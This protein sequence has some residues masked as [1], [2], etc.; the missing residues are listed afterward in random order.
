MFIV[1]LAS[2]AGVLKLLCST[3]VTR[4]ERASDAA[5]I[6]TIIIHWSMPK[7]TGITTKCHHRH[8]FGLWQVSDKCISSCGLV[9]FRFIMKALSRLND[10]PPFYLYF[11]VAVTSRIVPTS[12]QASHWDSCGTSV[13]T[14]CNWSI[15]VA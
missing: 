4:T 5:S 14:Y 8:L 13:A 10:R 11:T 1:S 6:P 12:S 2:A 15:A 7:M 3:C 9:R